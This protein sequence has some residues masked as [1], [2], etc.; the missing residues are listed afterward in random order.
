VIVERPKIGIVIGTTRQG[1]FGDKPAR[2]ILSA[3]SGRSDLDFEVVDLR[4]YPLPLFDEATGPAMAPPENGT[5]LRFGEKMAELDGYVF[6]TAEYNHGI[7]GSLKNALD[8]V[9]PECNGKP[10]AFVGYGGVGG[11]RAVEQLRLVCIE[12]Q[13]A[14]TRT[15]VHIGQEPLLGVLK[16]GKELSDFGYLKEAAEAMLDELAWWARTLKAG[17]DVEMETTKETGGILERSGG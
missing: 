4:D 13:M 6:V 12:L 3:A 14:P 2:W 16:G 9:Y 10:A 11:A 5:A 15:A 7:P 17:R 8:H 1:R